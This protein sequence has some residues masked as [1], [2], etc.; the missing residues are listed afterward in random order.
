[1]PRRRGKSR[2]DNVVACES[3]TDVDSV[4]TVPLGSVRSMS[5]ADR[6]VGRNAGTSG[7]EENF[8]TKV[9]IVADTDGGPA[10]EL[11]PMPMPTVQAPA[12]EAVWP[13]SKAPG[14][15]LVAAMA[16]VSALA[17]SRLFSSWLTPTDAVLGL[18]DR[19]DTG[20]GMLIRES[21]K[22]SVGQVRAPKVVVLVHP[23][24]RCDL[25]GLAR[26]T[27]GVSPGPSPSSR[28]RKL[29]K[30]FDR[31]S[32]RLELLEKRICLCR[33]ARPN[34]YETS[35]KWID[36]GPFGSSYRDTPFGS[37]RPWVVGSADSQ[38]K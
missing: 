36:P 29:S 31:Y 11:M 30:E 21:G 8:D 35:A 3:D 2:E 26:G 24:V 37:G 4:W 19:F 38:E 16:M 23:V 15:M 14:A 9:D 13:P 6:A 18:F 34:P 1:V 28:M 10:S 12:A 5:V 25:G 32:E 20:V 27:L 33:Q 17:V 22:A 7:R